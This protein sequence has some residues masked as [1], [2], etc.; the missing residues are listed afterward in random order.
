MGY[1]GEVSDEEW[2]F[3]Q[4]FLTLMKEEAAQREYGLREVF[5]TLRWLVR[6]G[7]PWRMLPNDVAPWRLVRQQT[8]RCVHAGCFEAM[9]HDPAALVARGAGAAKPYVHGGF[10][11]TVAPCNPRRKAARGPVKTGPSGGWAP[12]CMPRWTHWA[13][14]WR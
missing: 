3:C 8:Q 4:P 5:N 12:R 10:A 2:A 14:C 11:R 1:I 13:I 9:A 7:R 6:A